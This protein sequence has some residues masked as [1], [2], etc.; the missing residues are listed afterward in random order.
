M[1]IGEE[2]VTT[3]TTFIQPGIL[4]EC[5]KTPQIPLYFV[6]DSLPQRRKSPTFATV[7]Y[8][9]KSAAGT[10]R[11]SELLEYYFN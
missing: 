8:H 1:G 11:W 4:L 5:R 2:S 9:T 3:L 6:L 10:V 7:N